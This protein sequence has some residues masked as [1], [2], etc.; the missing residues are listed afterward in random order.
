M[1]YSPSS[2]PRCIWHSSFR[3]IQSELY[4]KISLSTW[5]VTAPPATR[6]DSQLMVLCQS[7]SPLSLPYA[8]LSYLHCPINNKDIKA[9]KMAPIPPPHT[10][11]NK[12]ILALP[13]FV[14]AVNRGR[15]F[16]AQKSASLCFRRPLLTPPEP[17][18]VLFYDGW[19]HFF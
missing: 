13:S 16:E 7:R 17:C 14:M 11:I 3:W 15:D 1:N 18:G 12:N 9:P 4:K 19:M 8:F 6:F 5:S 10:K 2:H